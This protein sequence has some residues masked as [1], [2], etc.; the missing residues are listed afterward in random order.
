MAPVKWLLRLVLIALC[1]SVT[2][3]LPSAAK[4]AASCSATHGTKTESLYVTV[5]MTVHVTEIRCKDGSQLQRH[6]THY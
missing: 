6:T 4:L 3:A 5:H 1:S 2:T